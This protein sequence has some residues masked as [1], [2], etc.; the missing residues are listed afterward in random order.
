MEY[1]S[2]FLLIA[3]AVPA[4]AEIHQV[5]SIRNLVESRGFSVTDW[6]QQGNDVTIKIGKKYPRQGQQFTSNYARCSGS[7]FNPV[8]DKITVRVNKLTRL[9]QVSFERVYHV[10]GHTT[11]TKACVSKGEFEKKL[12]GHLWGDEHPDR[13][14]V[15]PN[16]GDDKARKTS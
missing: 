1:L 11:Q 3:F 9:M 6:D 16:I 5:T 8:S 4:A 10:R 12:A 7:S 2:L 13:W 14:D 15:L